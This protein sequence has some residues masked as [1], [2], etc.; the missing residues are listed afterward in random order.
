[1]HAMAIMTP[2]P[3][4]CAALSVVAAAS[5]AWWLLHRH[6]RKPLLEEPVEGDQE[7]LEGESHLLLRMAPAIN[8]V[9]FYEGDAGA[10][11]A[12][13]RVRVAEVVGA[14]PWLAGRLAR[15]SNSRVRLS[16]QCVPSARSEACFG[17]AEAAAALLD[18]AVPYEELVRG[19]SLRFS[20][21]P[22]SACVSA[23]LAPSLYRV[24]VVRSPAGSGSGSGSSTSGRF[25]V[26]VSLSHMV[27]DGATFYA[28][29]GM[30]SS[31]GGGARSLIVARHRE[32]SEDV[33]AALG[34]QAGDGM[35]RCGDDSGDWLTSAG[36]ML[37][38]ART[39]LL[40]RAPRVLQAAVP[41]AWVA[42]EKAK[43]A[44]RR[45]V[46]GEKT[47]TFVSTNDLLTSALMTLTGC[48]VGLMAV[49]FRGRLP[50]LSSDWAGNYGSV[51]AYRGEQDFGSSSHIRRSLQ[52]P[53]G[54]VRR[55]HGER[56]LPGFAASLAARVTL[57]T[58][59]ATFHSDL[60]LPKAALKH[61]LPL[62]DPVTVPMTH[63]AFIFRPR[64]G[65]LA[66][67]VLS[68]SL[69]QSQLEQALSA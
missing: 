44:L 18:P 58:S 51:V 41:E 67:L 17:E 65:C 8:T 43:E 63:C 66:V 20:V 5:V 28:L 2:S 49:N 52:R 47:P 69:T 54:G 62:V 4:V 46:M 42:N 35:L 55:V 45:Q 21:P 24:T 50:P 32:Y 40:E 48:Q 56:P 13:L 6:P 59:W 23:Q 37:G 30:L 7:L 31:A 38:I 16:W 3:P 22:G 53:G 12:H 33:K 9:T 61:H 1:M 39:L 60:I 64:A 36:A 14:N 34:E 27:A 25:A 10:A 57:V 19:L 15:G 68:H 26:V 11:A 29:Y